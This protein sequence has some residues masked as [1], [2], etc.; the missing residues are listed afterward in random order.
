MNLTAHTQGTK[1]LPYSVSLPRC[2]SFL[3]CKQQSSDVLFANGKINTA[4]LVHMGSQTSA[5][6]FRTNAHKPTNTQAI[7]DSSDIIRLVN[8]NTLS[9]FIH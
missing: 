7:A 5:L 9:A 6:V 2:L 8:L 3:L 1:C 4:R